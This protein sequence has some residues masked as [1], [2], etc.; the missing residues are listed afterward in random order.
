MSMIRTNPAPLQEI[1]VKFAQEII[2]LKIE[3]TN[4]RRQARVHIKLTIHLNLAKHST[5]PDGQDL[6][7]QGLSGANNQEDPD[8]TKCQDPYTKANIYEEEVEYEDLVQEKNFEN[9]ELTHT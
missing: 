7:N 6:A 3:P 5:G 4:R 2:K 9:S 8:H 1:N